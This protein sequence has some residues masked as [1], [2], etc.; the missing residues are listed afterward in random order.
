M[1]RLESGRRINVIPGGIDSRSLLLIWLV[2]PP[3]ETGTTV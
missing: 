1:V 3:I 2:E